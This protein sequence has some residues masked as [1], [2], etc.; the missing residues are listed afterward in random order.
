M[1]AAEIVRADQDDREARVQ[2]IDLAM[3]EPPDQARGRVADKA[4]IERVV[5]GVILVPDRQDVVVAGRAAALPVLRDGIAQPDDLGVRVG[6]CL[7]ERFLETGVPPGQVRP[8]DRGHCEVYARLGRSRGGK[9][10]QK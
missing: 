6:F 1:H 2:A 10:E 3:I 4:E 8:A 7:G 9:R 5:G